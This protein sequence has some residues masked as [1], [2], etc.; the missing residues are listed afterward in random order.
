MRLLLSRLPRLR[1]ALFWLALFWLAPFRLTRFRLTRFRLALFWLAARSRLPLPQPAGGRKA[2][3]SSLSRA[4]PSRFRSSNRWPPNG[5]AAAAAWPGRGCR[6]RRRPARKCG[7]TGIRRP[8]PDGAPRNRRPRLSAAR[9]PPPGCRSAFRGPTWFRVRSANAACPPALRR[10]L[11]GQP[12]RR[13]LPGSRGRPTPPAPASPGSSAVPAG[14]RRPVPRPTGQRAHDA[15]LLMM[16]AVHKK[17][18]G[19]A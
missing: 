10:C 5:S 4:R 12:G 3:R 6:V 17:G 11:P 16:I 2:L 13:G 9:S 14:R 7:P 15:R 1:L 18:A 8:T 19:V